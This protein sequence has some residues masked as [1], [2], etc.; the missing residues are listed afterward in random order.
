MK[1]GDLIIFYLPSMAIITGNS[2]T[3]RKLYGLII[4]IDDFTA[5]VIHNGKTHFWPVDN[6]ELVSESR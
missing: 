5:I 1:A 6:C 3:E 4:S 2:L